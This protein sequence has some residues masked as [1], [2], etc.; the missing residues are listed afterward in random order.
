MMKLFIFGIV[1]AAVLMIPIVGAQE[2]EKATFQES[3]TVIIDQKL[4]NSVIVSTSFETIDNSEIRFSDNLIEKINA[5]EKIRSIVFTNVGQ[6]VIGVTS[7]QQ[8][9]MV[10][11]SYEELKGDGGI[12]RVQ[13]SARIMGDSIISE[14][15]DTFRVNTEFHSTFIHT[16]DD[17]NI[18]MQTSGIVSGRGSVSATYVTD[19]SATDFLFSDLSGVLLPREIREGG[20][21]YNI[22]SDIAKDDNA[23]I[24][25]SIIPSEEQNIYIFKVTKEIKDVANDVSEI[26]I[27]ESLGVNEISRTDYFDGRNVPLNSVV[28]LIVIPNE[29]KNVSAIATHV[30]TDMTSIENIMKKGWFLSSPAGNM[31]DMRFLFGETKTV[32]ADELRVETESWDGQ[33]EIKLY[34]VEEINEGKV[35]GDEKE[36]ITE[37][38]MQYIVLGIIIIVG[39]GAA[40]FYLKGYK[41]KR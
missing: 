19:K 4:S 12:A 11:F 13:E 9:I 21:F 5:N 24:S 38:N 10:N 8:C 15:N 40:I 31:I 23:M 26:N 2:F 20:G 34:S 3:A 39:I 41:P 1:F 18:L 14:L 22:M 7:E 17:A 30:I 32:Y 27:L 6:C 36:E 33:S 28:Q 35:V 37:D 16:V 29:A 25:V